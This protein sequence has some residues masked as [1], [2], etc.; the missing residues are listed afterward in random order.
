MTKLFPQ[1]RLIPLICRFLLFWM[2]LLCCP[3]WAEDKSFVT[4]IARNNVALTIVYSGEATL[5]AARSFQNSVIAANPKRKTPANVVALPLANFKGTMPLGMTYVFFLIGS[6]CGDQFPTFLMPVLPADVRTP[7]ETLSVLESRITSDRKNAGAFNI[8][9][10]APDAERFARLHDD[11]LTRRFGGEFRDMG[12]VSRRVVSNKVELFSSPELRGLVENWG[13]MSTH[14]NVTGTGPTREVWDYV[15]WHD[16]AERDAMSAQVSPE[17][18]EV[19]FF[20][21]SQQAAV[22]QAAAPALAAVQVGATTICTSRINTPDGRSIVV[23]SAPNQMLLEGRMAQYPNLATVPGGPQTREAVD[24]RRIGRTVLLVNGDAPKEEREAVRLLLAREMRQQ[25]GVVVD[26]RGTEFF[27]TLESEDS[28]RSLM[29]ESSKARRDR[30]RREA[31][32]EYIWM[33]TLSEYSGTTQFATSETCTTPDPP[34]FSR[35]APSKPS[36]KRLFGRD[37]SE[38]QYQRALSRYQ[39]EYEDWEEERDRYEERVENADYQWRRVIRCDEMASARGVLRLVSLSDKGKVE[40]EQQCSGDAANSRTHRSDTISVRGRTGRPSSLDSPAAITSCANDLMRQAAF[41]AGQQALGLLRTEAWLPDG[42]PVE[43]VSTPNEEPK[44][45]VAARS[46]A[47]AVSEAPPVAGM[48]PAGVSSA[49][50]SSVVPRGN[51]PKI[52]AINGKTAFLT[53]GT[54]EGLRF[55]DIITVELETLDVKNPETG[56]VLDHKVVDTLQL[57]VVG[58][59]KTADCVAN[60][61]ADEAKWEKMKVGM[62]IIRPIAKRQPQKSI[63]PAKATAKRK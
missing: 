10:F 31:R 53:I 52:A 61:P 32:S 62:S 27:Q 18:N 49:T 56:E 15:Q 8:V 54:K 1:S 26:E 44:T 2:S 16:L 7:Q 20:D 23:F 58:G 13:Q 5:P 48:S 29:G 9:L 25:L 50:T 36:K 28:L 37:L 30:A 39:R 60:T 22:P 21:R 38:E 42:K 45:T 47:P 41:K 35:S 14:A 33:Y 59:T 40:W 6:E 11:F 46:L 4:E 24:L 43:E 63:V 19:Y 12:K 55:G 34:A 51:A 17:Q 57:R 3:V